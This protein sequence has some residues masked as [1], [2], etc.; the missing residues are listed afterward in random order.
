MEVMGVLMSWETFVMSSVFR[1]SDFIRS[2]TARCTPAPTLPRWSAWAR[3]SGSAQRERG[4]TGIVAAGE[5]FARLL[6]PPQIERQQ[7][8]REDDRAVDE[9]HDEQ[10]HPSPL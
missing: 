6:Q 2:S 9:Q 4:R 8:R 1:C 10:E 5:L 7:Q 3:R